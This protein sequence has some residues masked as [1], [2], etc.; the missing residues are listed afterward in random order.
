[1]DLRK[2]GAIAP[3]RWLACELHTHTLHS[4]GRHTLYELALGAAAQELDW[5]ALTDHNTTSGLLGKE[6]V[7]R[8]AGISILNGLE[9]TT[10]YGHMLLLGL[11][12][13]D[14][15]D[16]RMLGPGDLAQGLHE[17]KA[18]GALAGLAHPYRVGSPMCTGCYWEYE[19]ADWHKIDFIEVW[20]GTFPSVRT[21]NQRAFA[22]WTEVLN[23]GYRVAA[24]CGRDW[25]DSASGAA[26]REPVAVTYIA[27]ENPAKAIAQGAV[28][29]S[30]GPLLTMRA[31]G[32]GSAA[33]IGEV[34]TLAGGSRNV[35]VSVRLDFE[36]RASVWT[37]P[38]QTL[39]IRLV[40]NA[41]IIQSVAMP[42]GSSAAAVL[43][44]ASAMTWLRAELHGMLNGCRTMIAFTNAIY[45]ETE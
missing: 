16:W 11:R 13:G 43:I 32:D 7:E 29:V 41:G 20:S 37:L 30:M 27:K 23:R 28:A 1:M 25:H 45:F 31:A 10:F 24:T 2:S 34:L 8:A 14:Y 18:L 26:E 3:D 6:E 4:D 22:L 33:G 17:A 42:A 9:W 39:E 38:E 21:S 40:G 12:E 15:A 36:R 19:I 44:D 5:I 35:E